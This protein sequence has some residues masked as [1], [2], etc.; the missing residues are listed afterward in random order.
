MEKE[1]IMD[2]LEKHSYKE[3]K[4]ELENMHPVDI[5]EILEELDEKQMILIFRLLAKEEAAEVFTDMNSDMR[6]DLINALTDSELEE[7]MEEMYVDDTVDVLEEMP[8]N[9]VDRLLLATDEDTRVKINALLQ[10][11]EDSAG[12]IMN[13]EYI[14]LRREMTV[15][16]AILKIRQVGINKETIY[17]CY[18]TEKRHL[19]GMVDVKDLL[20]AGESR[21]IEEIM[22]ENVLYAR[23]LD[24]QEDVA[25]TIKKYGLVAIP[26]IDHENCLVGIVTVDDAMLVLQDETTEDISIMAGVSPNEDSYF[27]TSVFKHAGNRTPWLMLLMLSATVTGEILGYY[28]EAMAIM[29]VLITFIPMLMGT[30]GNCGSQSST[31]IIRG[32]AVG[33][34]QFKDIFRVIFK[35]IRIAL[36][37][38]M[39][40]AFVN[41]IRIYIMY[42][43]NIMLSLALGLTMIAVVVMAKC[44]GCTLPLLAKKLGLDPA[45]MAA[46]LITTILDTCTILVYFNIVTVFF[47]L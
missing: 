29:P 6:E 40:L 35:E 34:I 28:E 5:V 27:G 23:T 38:S 2:L 33:E 43:Q 30:G 24:D 22:D 20:T 41:G 8:A 18:V 42:G 46:P 4:E 10:Y 3:L 17:T 39:M 31:L 37:V 7:V 21:L 32:L 26:I 19:I 12:S 44:I 15:A 11:P 36:I 13:V 47:G 25:K 1:K 16:D 14:S 9:V 45:I